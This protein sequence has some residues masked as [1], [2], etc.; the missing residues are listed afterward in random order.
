[1]P[2]GGSTMPGKDKITEKQSV[3]SVRRDILLGS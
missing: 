3:C 2:E 1:M